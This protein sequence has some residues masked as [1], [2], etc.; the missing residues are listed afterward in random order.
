[1]HRREILEK[2]ARHIPYD[3]HERES[4][5][6]IIE[7]V[8]TTL[9][10]FDRSHLAGHVTGSAW[11]LNHDGTKVLLTHHRKLNKWLQLGGHCDGDANVLRVAIREAQEES[12]VTDIEPLTD[13]VFD[14]DVHPIPQHGETP[15]H[16][17]YD[18]RFL[19]RVTSESAA[20][21]IQIS[22]ESH[23]LAW[24]ARD[25]IERLDTDESVR[26]MTKKW[27]PGFTSGARIE[28]QLANQPRSSRST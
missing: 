28:T 5:R 17:H 18:I 27:L 26:R 20:A 1:M 16:D 2:L 24:F 3:A 7:F 6:R 22:D 10:C 9:P 23:D 11:V 14:V 15:A 19:L 21:N 8:S 13:A 25:E 12:G 4:L